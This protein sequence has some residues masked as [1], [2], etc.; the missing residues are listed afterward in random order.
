MK[1]VLYT[2]VSEENLRS[3]LLTFYECVGLSIQIINEHGQILASEGESPGSA[4]C[5]RSIFLPM[6]PA[7][8]SIFPPAKKRLSWE[9]PTSFPAMRS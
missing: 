1:P 7:K 9:A 6:K 8:N 3:M 4:P 5:F 2:I